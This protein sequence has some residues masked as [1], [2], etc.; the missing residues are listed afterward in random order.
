[1]SAEVTLPEEAEPPIRVWISGV[2]QTE[3]EDYEVCGRTVRFHR[4]IVQEGRLGVWRWLSMFLGLVGTYRRHD[5]V[6]LQYR[7][8]GRERLAA[9]VEVTGARTSADGSG[10]RTDGRDA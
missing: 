2:A 7:A 5:A 10:V 1:M 4:P 9:D 6:D 8:G 3:D